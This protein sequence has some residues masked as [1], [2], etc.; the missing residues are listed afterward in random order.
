MATTL[1]TGAGFD[2]E[3]GVPSGLATANMSMLWF[4]TGRVYELEVWPLYVTWTL[5]EVAPSR[6][7]GT[8]Q[9]ISF[10]WTETSWAVMPSKVT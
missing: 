8:K 4:D 10:A 5:A 6:A 7:N 2:A 3:F 1:F 9:T